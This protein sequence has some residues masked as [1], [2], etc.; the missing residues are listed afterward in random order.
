[1]TIL[2]SQTSDDGL[3][4]PTIGLC[5]LPTASLWARRRTR[6]AP[7]RRC[8]R[9]A[10]TSTIPCSVTE[11]LCGL[12][13]P[14]CRQGCCRIGDPR[15]CSATRSSRIPSLVV[16]MFRARATVARASVTASWARCCAARACSINSSCRSAAGVAYECSLN[17]ASSSDL[18]RARPTREGR[19]AQ[20]VTVRI[21]RHHGAPRGLNIQRR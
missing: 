14:G 8:H 2:G 15:L 13:V 18:V 21:P 7:S 12:D 9:A 19:G 16:M 17:V 10:E 11:S 3:N 20:E 1:M 4:P 5:T 6:R